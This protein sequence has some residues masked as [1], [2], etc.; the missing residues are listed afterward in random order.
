M[1]L[2]TPP[3]TLSWLLYHMVSFHVALT[4]STT[5]LLPLVLAFSV[6]LS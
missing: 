5:Y 4:K 3:H 2:V 1:N 6:F